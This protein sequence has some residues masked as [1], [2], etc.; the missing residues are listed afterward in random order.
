[1]RKYLN[2]PWIVTALALGA[3][4]FVW[5]SLRPARV[6]HAV[7]TVEA[8]GP[9]AEETS[10]GES[11][12]SEVAAM[13]IE[14]ALKAVA[15]TT[16]PGDPFAPR[17]K[18]DSLNLHPEPAVP[19]FVDTVKLSA[20]WTQE[21]RTYVVINDTIHEA[22]DAISRITIESATQH[23]VWVA[24]WKGRDFVALGDDFTLVTPGGKTMTA[25]SL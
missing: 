9:T 18:T 6:V 10:S 20:I 16:L 21:G 12:P 15:L 22:G 5:N 13:S 19:D 2:N 3:V 8:A 24:H 17:N 25:A 7:Q 4:A 11:A 23:G 14:Q 1:M